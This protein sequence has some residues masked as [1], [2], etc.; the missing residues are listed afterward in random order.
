MYVRKW[1]ASV[2]DRAFRGG[3]GVGV[4]D[5][6]SLCTSSSGGHTGLFVGSEFG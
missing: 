4:R 6:G 2:K 1:S 3:G 5:I